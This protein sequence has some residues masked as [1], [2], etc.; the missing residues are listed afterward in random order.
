M[1]D[2]VRY[3]ISDGVAV[4]TIA[5]PPVNAL[6]H[7]VRAKLHSLIERCSVDGNIKA[8]V[9]AAE[10]R[11]FPA[12][13]DIS[14]FGKKAEQPLLPDLCSTIEAIEK[15]VVA[16]IHGTAL[17]GGFEIALAAH[18]RVADARAV[19][20]LPE[21]KL[22]LIPG[23][24]GT[25]RAPRLAGAA[26]ALDMMLSGDPV[27]AT[28]AQEWGLV[29]AV[30]QDDVV[31]AAVTLAGR[32]ADQ[33]VPPLRAC[34]RE[35]ARKDP[36]AW[37]N[38]IARRRK[39]L[40][41]SPV[42]APKRIV[43]CVEAVQLLPFD[44]ALAFERAA[45]EDV[46]KSDQSAALRHAFFAERRAAK[47]PDLAG[48]APHNIE[49]IGIVGGGT[50]GSGIAVACLDAGLP[51]ILV[52]KD[53]EA[54]EAAVE[55]VIDIY[56]RQVA[57]KKL[58]P[59]ARDKR[60]AN[61]NGHPELGALAEADLIVETVPEDAK[62]KHDVFAKLNAIA[63]P[64]TILATNTSYLDLNEI[65]QASGRPAMVVGLHFFSPAQI[66]RLIEVVPGAVTSPEVT[67]TAF[68]L[69]RRLGKIGVRA[70]VTDGFVGN[71][72]LAA[73][74]QA[75]EYLLEDGASVQEIDNAMRAFG[76]PLGPFQVADLAGLDIAWARRRRLA[77]T[78][79]P[80]Q[81]YV[82]IPDRLCELGRLGRKVGRGW[83]IYPRGGNRLGEVDPEVTSI[84]NEERL[85]Q[86]IKPRSF[87]ADEIQRRCLLAMI[88]EGTRLLE[89]GIALRPSDID[90]VMMHGF[91]FPRW[92]GGPMKAADIIGLMQVRKEMQALAES[93]RFFWRPAELLTELIK[94]GRNFE[95]LNV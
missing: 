57:R 21:V 41:N 11:T 55:R 66:M 94:N 56:D 37:A 33:E 63:R 84:I 86:G 46:L 80:A 92:R 12:G 89:E 44:A 29:D 36:G 35:P 43:D 83:Y 6:S 22:G 10:G 20:G 87:T 19:V 93:D 59:E 79:D 75:A 77:A 53:I 60:V 38:E 25:Q 72:V 64:G 15:P 48:V 42:I 27:P 58:S 85:F 24:G 78:R 54:L 47:Q 91:A 18:A 45:F 9:I 71:R 52:E 2:P 74:R 51:V 68:A 5:N 62:L 32:L 31:A 90:V 82:T 61:L 65:A 14:E 30:S 17:G 1:G 26:A 34:E 67:A 8:I 69:A 81:R 39:A 76:F 70:G 3:H 16:A 50:M 7:P 73:Y 4:L 49:K 95:T 88:N 28:K 23:A 13:A 40:E